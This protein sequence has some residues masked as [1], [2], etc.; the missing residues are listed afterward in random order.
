M[1]GGLIQLVSFGKQDGYLT[2]NP[3]ITYFK[4]NYRRHTI[5]GIELI[6][7]IPEQQ[8]EYDNKISFKLNNISDLISKCYV[9]IELPSLLFTE[10]PNITSLKENQLSNIIKNIN[11]WKSLYENLKKF[12]IIEIQLYQT[13]N[14]FLQSIN[15]N[16]LNIKQNTIKFNAKY[17]KIKDELINLIFDDIFIDINLTGYILQLNKIIVNDNDNNYDST[18]HIKKSNLK[19]DVNNYYK[20]MIKHMTYYHSNWKFNQNNYNDIKNKNVN[21]A[22]IE[23][24]AHYFFT[25]FE[26]EIGGN[27][28]EKYSADQSF[29]YQTHHI[30][31]EQKKIYNELIGNKNNLILFNNDKKNTTTLI[32]PLNFWFCKDIGSSLPAVA[33]SNSSISIN[34]K[35]NKLKNLI[36]F[37][38]Y[39]KEYYNLLNITIQY[40]KTI[41]TKLVFDKFKYNTD[42]KL[43]TYTCTHINYELLAL[44]YPSLSTENKIDTLFEI[45]KNYGKDLSGNYIK[46]QSMYNNGFDLELN[47]VYMDL[48]E[49]IRYKINYIPS[50]KYILEILDRESLNDYNKYYSLIELPKIKLISECIYLDDIERSS[51]SSSKLEYVIELFQENLFD[52]N[53]KLLFNGELSLDRPTKEL[54]WTTQPKIFLNGLCEFGKAYTSYDYTKFF[55]NNIYSNYNIS[56]NQMQLTKP[57]LTEIFYNELQ[58]YKYYNNLLPKGVFAYNFGIFPENIQP[59]G[60]ANFT[61]LKGKLINFNLNSKFVE[62][63]FDE[64]NDNK[65]N[66]NDLGILLK[67]YSRSYN[68]FVVE[69]GMGNILFSN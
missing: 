64:I 43:T 6:E 45:I 68:F 59:S 48:N 69:K 20:N 26:L 63:Y 8:P 5:F 57:K 44:Q 61:M 1:T 23:N 54:I 30:K 18:I 34:L 58:S 19:L 56:L 4:K 39:E 49:W 16:L 29:I 17:K 53:K 3:Q 40:D 36:Y 24:L 38:D 13:L 47:G 14:N 37:R 46:N 50:S 10:S 65:I 42:S 9:E 32:L 7:N 2:F 41:H 27:V 66:P 60:T 52:L 51:F 21:F 33:L 55:K 31:E 67:F 35:L 15:I 62:E 12:C 11:K 28:V 22:W 25:D